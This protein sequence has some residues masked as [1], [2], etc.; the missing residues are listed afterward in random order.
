[1][2]EATNINE[3]SVVRLAVPKGS[4]QSATAEFLAKA[5]LELE[6]YGKGSRNYRPRISASSRI[7][8][9]IPDISEKVKVKVLRPQ[10]IPILVSRGYYDLGISGLDWYRE[11]RCE[12]NVSDAVDLGFGRVDIVLA[13][14]ETWSDVNDAATLFSKYGAPTNT[15]PL[16]I[17]TEYLNL[18][19]DFILNFENTEPSIISPYVGLKR[20]TFG[21]R[22]F[23]FLWGD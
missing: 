15:K 23:P 4:L 9:E 6:G 11:S 2:R 17:W 14:P 3:T 22:N 18:S 7:S 1:M 5:G 21:H 12:R 8:N 16:R 10:E 20:E 19:E 13:V